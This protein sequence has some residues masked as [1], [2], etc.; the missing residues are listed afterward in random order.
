MRKLFAL[1]LVCFMMGVLMASCQTE[2][3]NATPDE[4]DEVVVETV[5]STESE[6]SSVDE[7]VSADEESQDYLWDGDYSDVVD[8]QEFYDRSQIAEYYANITDEDFKANYKEAKVTVVDESTL[9]IEYVFNE[10]Y[11]DAGVKSMKLSFDIDESVN[12]MK[13]SAAD[14]VSYFENSTQI[15]NPKI[16]FKYTD[17]NGTVLYDKTFAKEDTVIEDE[18]T[19]NATE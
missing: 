12:A 10:T 4:S 2:K 11:D 15:L 18:T 1:L 8:M 7:T 19:V 3:K 14:A 17:L 16:E 5:A 9:C 6:G 13:A